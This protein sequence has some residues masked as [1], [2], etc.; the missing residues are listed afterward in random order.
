M[1]HQREVLDA[2]ITEYDER[3]AE[4]SRQLAQTDRALQALLSVRFRMDL[5]VD[6]GVA[7][8]AR[9]VAASRP[10]AWL[11]SWLSVVL[12]RQTQPQKMQLQGGTG[13]RS[14]RAAS[15]V[16]MMQL[17]R[18]R[19]L[20]VQLGQLAVFAAVA[21][22]LRQ[23]CA[24]QGLHSQVGTPNRYTKAALATC[25]RTWRSVVGGD[26]TQAASLE[27]S[28]AKEGGHRVTLQESGRGGAVTGAANRVWGAVR[29]I[30][31]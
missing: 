31:S 19:R 3:L 11:L 20:A 30:M 21:Q 29:W 8:L 28:N 10:S 9:W 4:Q 15:R 14:S 16:A 12:V 24:E 17:H 6:I 25:M 22:R 26:A 23:V 13:G 27:G 18:R 2:A 1:Q 5:V 7:L